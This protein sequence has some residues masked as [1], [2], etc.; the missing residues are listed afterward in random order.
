[1]DLLPGLKLGPY[2]IMAPL[3]AGG[4]G[5]VYR[6][7]DTRLGRVVALK[8]LP[9][10][11]SERPE[12]RERFERE[13]RAISSLNHPNVCHL[14][15]VGV[16][17]GISYL[18]MEYLEGETLA[19]RLRKGP[20]ALE[21]VLRYG[22]EVA[23][24]LDCAHRRG[25]IHRDLKSANIFVTVHGECKVLDFGL[26][27]QDEESSPDAE[28]LTLPEV[29]TSPGTAV[30]TV[31]YMSPEQARGESMDAR[32][33]IFSLGAVLYEI[34]TGK[35]PF[36][37]KTSAVVFKAIMDETPASPVRLNALIPVKL[38]E[39]IMK[40]LEKDPDLRYQTAA[41]IR[42]DLKRMKRDTTS[43][44]TEADPSSVS[45]SSG[46]SAADILPRK[47]SSSS[48]VL[49]A[50]AR[51][52]KGL[53]IG[54]TVAALLLV[55]AAIV[56]V[57]NLVYKAV[58]AIDTQKITLQQLTNH[59]QVVSSSGIAVSSDGKWLAYVKREGE[60]SLRVRQ[61]A[62]GSEISVVP[63]Q[64]G[65]FFGVTFSPD[66]SRVLFSHTDP[67]NPNTNILYAVPTLGGPTHRLVG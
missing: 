59:R 26:A 54:A 63:A 34:S 52:H 66:G 51:R 3:G 65:L 58:D 14:Y 7:R 46:V 39:I 4:M 41:E 45:I 23:D 19:D 5:E 56:G 2:E 28:T 53:T 16:D 38:D 57:H 29:L 43:G 18:V 22:A 35:L 33:D 62:T 20:V 1:M 17:Q 48:S 64:S 32:S 13:G 8:I 12:S 10:H 36:N 44:K 61:I 24:A 40:A 47:R 27:K 37:G 67:A 15:D 60:R 21:Q 6:A 9:Q 55:G 42:G 11:L 50:E 31:A 49:L 25:I 30:G